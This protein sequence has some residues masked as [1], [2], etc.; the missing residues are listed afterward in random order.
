MQDYSQKFYQTLILNVA[1][2]CA[3]I[4]GTFQFAVR[5]FNDNNGKEKVRQFTLQVVK[6]MNTFLE[7]FESKLESVEV[8]PVSIPQTTKKIRNRK[9]S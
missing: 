2:I 8:S 5:S 3:I 9:S 7:V 6:F 4:V 1:T